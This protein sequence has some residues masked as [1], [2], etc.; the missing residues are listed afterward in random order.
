MNSP[1][2]LRLSSQPFTLHLSAADYILGSA[3]LATQLDEKLLKKKAWFT[4]TLQFISFQNNRLTLN[5]MF[6]EEQYRLQILVG[7]AKLE[8]ACSCN[9]PVQT[10]C[11]HAYRALKD[12]A[13][14][15]GETYF[16]Q[17]APGNWAQT[18]MANKNHFTFSHQSMEP[19]FRALPPH[20]NLFDLNRSL[21]PVTSLLQPPLNNQELQVCYL[22]LYFARRKSPPVLMPCLGIPNKTG[23]QVKSFCSFT[24]TIDTANSHYFNDTQKLLNQYC[25]SMI[26]EAEQIET[27]EHE[28]YPVWHWENYSNLFALWQ[29]CWPLL[30]TQPLVYSSYM[31]FIKYIKGK[32][33]ARKTKR[34]NPLLENPLPQFILS[35]FPGHHRFSMKISAGQG[36][37]H[38]DPAHL[39]FFANSV[40]YNSIYL[41][42]SLP[43][44]RLATAMSECTPFL[45]VFN[46]QFKSFQSQVI[47]P[48]RKLGLLKK[49]PVKKTKALSSKKKQNKPSKK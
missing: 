2:N 17:F 47:T 43:L 36:Q 35:S 23:I 41:F 34:V 31:Y 32:P 28:Y 20:H 19:S 16:K 26:R 8:I 49:A 10:L 15:R 1:T 12:I 30:C 6:N 9:Q 40:Q 48:L 39:P 14:S 22:I 4:P 21:P 7:S 44:A 13:W 29:K 25:L 38:S 37:L 24:E 3:D 5:C 27:K 45:S 33:M 46:P 11:L 18:A 42:N